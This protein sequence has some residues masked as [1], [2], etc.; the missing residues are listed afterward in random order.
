MSL[1]RNAITVV[2]RHQ[3]DEMASRGRKDRYALPVEVIAEPGEPVIIGKKGAF[4]NML[5]GA[6][7][8]S[9]FHC[10][11]EVTPDGTVI[12]EGTA[13]IGTQVTSATP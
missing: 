13:S 5:V 6:P 7:S 9:N 10:A 11:L 8:T 2:E 4:A 1:Q 12:I 3:L